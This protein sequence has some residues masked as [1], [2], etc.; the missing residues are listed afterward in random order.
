MYCDPWTVVLVDSIKERDVKVQCH[1]VIC[2]HAAWQRQRLQ[3]A[4]QQQQQLSRNHGAVGQAL[5][6]QRKHQ[7]QQQL[8]SM[9]AAVR[10]ASNIQPERQLRKQRKHQQA[11][12]RAWRG[13]LSFSSS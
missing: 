7:Q 5:V 12:G 4:L 2:R 8:R 13:R 3:A 10:P 6:R 9:A 1:I 11:C